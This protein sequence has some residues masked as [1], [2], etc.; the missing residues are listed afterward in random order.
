MTNANKN[1]KIV[2]KDYRLMV[3]GQE[4]CFW[5]KNGKI[6]ISRDVYDSAKKE[7]FDVY[8]ERKKSLI[9]K[10]IINSKLFQ[11]MFR[12]EPRSCIITKNK[13]LC[14]SFNKSIFIFTENGDFVNCSKVRDEMRC[15]LQI[16]YVS[17]IDGFD[18]A[19]IYG[20]YGWNDDR[21]PVNIMRFNGK[22]WEP[23]YTFPKNTICHVHSI[24]PCKEKKCLFILTGDNDSE[25]GIWIAKEN[26]SQI[27]PILIGKQMY[28]SC[29]AIIK[30]GALFYATDTPVE[31]NHLF[32]FN[33][34]DEPTVLY[35]LPGTVINSINLNGKW[36]FSTAVEQNPNLPKLLHCLSSKI[37]KGIKDRYSHLFIMKSN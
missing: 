20:E 18:D 21:G 16:T 32:S 7:V 8:P 11:R 12:L 24:V 23:V 1:I 30:N 36:L 13:F 34:K 17:N 14:F 27:S 33:Y 35:D 4:H 19:L 31:E 9:K 26:F 15:P 29:A 37:A 28:R 22:M 6:Y 5:Y 3:V 25:S 2:S 10:I